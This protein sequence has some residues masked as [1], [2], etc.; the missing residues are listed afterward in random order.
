M[1]SG[2]SE[3]R[4]FTIISQR[5][6]VDVDGTG[7]KSYEITRRIP[8]S[9]KAEDELKK[10]QVAYKEELK[11]IENA[12]LT[13]RQ[14]DGLISQP[15]EDEIKSQAVVAVKEYFKDV[16]CKLD[17]AQRILTGLGFI[18]DEFIAQLKLESLDLAEEMKEKSM[19]EKMIFLSALNWYRNQWARPQLQR[20]GQPGLLPDRQ[21]DFPPR[22]LEPA[23]AKRT[24][25]RRWALWKSTARSWKKHLSSRRRA[26]MATNLPA[27][28]RSTAKKRRLS[29]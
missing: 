21:D 14:I 15:M 17:F 12:R 8:S 11:L 1:R 28:S 9:R 24:C 7:E 10:R 6:T 2:Q 25:A 27:R 29:P 23:R 26:S 3:E 18:D 20:A 4:D 5:L 16:E 19:I 13:C 22:S